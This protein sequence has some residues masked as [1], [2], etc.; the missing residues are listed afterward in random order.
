MWKRSTGVP[1]RGCLFSSAETPTCGHQV[2]RRKRRR[3]RAAL[4]RAAGRREDFA[5]DA[6]GTAELRGTRQPR[7]R[8]SPT[9]TVKGHRLVLTKPNVLQSA[10][11][12][13]LK[14]TPDVALSAAVWAKRRKD[15]PGVRFHRKRTFAATVRMSAKCKERTLASLFD[16]LVGAGEHGRWHGEIERF[17]GFE[18]D[19]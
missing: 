12:H 3:F 1:E 2:R 9:S 16:H 19:C 17:G 5:P 7:A 8:S 4:R 10:T 15:N 14:F 13:V 18:I 11:R 6:Q